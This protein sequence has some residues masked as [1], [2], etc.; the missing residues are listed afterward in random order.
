V[1]FGY[2]VGTSVYENF[3]MALL[4][5]LALIFWFFGTA[6][7]SLTLCSIIF[8]DFFYEEK[9]ELSYST[10]SNI[11]KAL[12]AFTFLVII[13]SISAYNINLYS[14]SVNKY[15]FNQLINYGIEKR[16]EVKD[17]Y[18]GKHKSV[19]FEF[20]IEDKMYKESLSLKNNYQVGDTIEIIV[21]KNNPTV[22]WYLDKLKKAIG[23]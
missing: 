10:K 11:K 15:E 3:L 22:V 18:Y 9:N 20:E 16:V 8:R 12:E 4:G 23:K 7:L 17:V 6:F 1:Y 14:K 19:G 21:S 5:I 2:I 13:I